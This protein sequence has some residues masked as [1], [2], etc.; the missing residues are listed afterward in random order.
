MF[1]GN[2]WGYHLYG[3]NKKPWDLLTV[4]YPLI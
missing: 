4:L 3:T 2:I 1:D